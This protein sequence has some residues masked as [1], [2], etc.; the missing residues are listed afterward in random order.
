MVNHRAGAEVI[1][2]GTTLLDR[3]H[4]AEQEATARGR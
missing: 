3:R 4:R 1:A 2:A